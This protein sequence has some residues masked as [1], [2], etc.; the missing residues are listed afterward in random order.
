MPSIF[1]LTKEQA[2]L[3]AKVE[4]G[5]FSEEDTAD[6]FEGMEHE[7]NDK[8]SDYCH[9]LNSMNADLTTIKNEI[10]RLKTLQGEKQNQTK[11]IKQ[12]LIAGLS[13]IE[14]TSFD[15]GLFKG[16]IRKGSQSVNV[17]NAGEIPAEYIETKVTESPD[18]TAIRN[19]LKAGE[20]VP[21]AELIT[22]DSSIVIK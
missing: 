3:K 6:T 11:R 14:K 5:V 21:G 13:G 1:E 18:K 7:L 2:E 12:T 19:A 8:I 9:V 15:T 20:K 17:L 16:H 4:Q 10:D 22:G